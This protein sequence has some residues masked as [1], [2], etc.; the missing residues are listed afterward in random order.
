MPFI[1][2]AFMH[3]PIL[4]RESSHNKKDQFQKGSCTFNMSTSYEGSLLDHLAEYMIYISN[5]S[6]FWFSLNPS[7]AHEFH[8]SK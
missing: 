1:G 5:A 3:E 2:N 6:S 4:T 7:N 8:L